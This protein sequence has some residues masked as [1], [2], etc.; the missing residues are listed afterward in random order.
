MSFL[1][2][3]AM[4]F[5]AAT[6]PRVSRTALR[7]MEKSLDE[8]ISRLWPDVPYLLIGPTRGVYLEGYGAVFTAEVNLVPNPS[9]LMAPVVSKADIARLH[10]LKLERIPLLKKALREALV[11]TAASLDTVPATEQVTIVALLDHYAWEDLSG[12]PSQVMVQAVKGKL[13]DA[14]RTGNVESVIQVSEN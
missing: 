13:L 6:A 1:L 11:S 5:A 7:A 10:Q 14:Q 3:A 2:L 8:Q 9:S 12:L 4:A